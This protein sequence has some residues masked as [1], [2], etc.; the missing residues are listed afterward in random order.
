MIFR[1]LRLRFLRESSQIY[2]QGETIDARI[3]GAKLFQR[4]L[5]FQESEIWK[6]TIHIR[7]PDIL[8]LKLRYSLKV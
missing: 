4:T 6:S 2:S 7:A 3:N 1:R 5:R 8:K